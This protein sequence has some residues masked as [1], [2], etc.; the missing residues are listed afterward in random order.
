MCRAVMGGIIRSF[1]VLMLDMSLFAMIS[2]QQMCEKSPTEK[3]KRHTRY[4][5]C[6]IMSHTCACT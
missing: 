6:I 2:S 4:K 5:L 1:T 3:Q